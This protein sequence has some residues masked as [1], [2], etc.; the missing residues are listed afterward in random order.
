MKFVGT[1]VTGKKTPDIH[2][3][4]KLDEAG[5]SV[6]TCAYGKAPLESK[7]SDNGLIASKMLLGVCRNCPHYKECCS[8]KQREKFNGRVAK[9]EE[10]RQGS[11]STADLVQDVP[12]EDLRAIP[13]RGRSSRKF[14]ELSNYRNGVEADVSYLRNTAR[15]DSMPQGSQ[16]TREAFFGVKVIAFNFRRYL[17]SCSKEAKVAGKA[18]KVA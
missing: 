2:A 8:D 11:R 5:R 13:N 6:V 16:K 17:L 1:N 14:C 10:V 18:V 3:D 4:H 9:A 12:E 7:P 15:V